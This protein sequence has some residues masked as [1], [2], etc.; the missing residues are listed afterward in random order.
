[1]ANLWMISDLHLGHKGILT[2]DH[3]DGGKLRD[4]DSL[5]QM[6]EYIFDIWQ[7]TVGAGDKVYVLG[8]VAFNRQA[9]LRMKDLKGSKR[10][11][12]GNHDLFKQKDYNEVFTQTYGVRQINRVWLTHVPM[13]PHSMDRAIVNVHGHLHS[14]LV[15]DPRY[16]NVSVEQINYK[17]ISM[18]T[19]MA[20]AKSRGLL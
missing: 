19:V 17:P 10:L 4:F 13:H 7:D 12:R 2:F 20:T 16:I 3:P 18:D 6:E 14:G 15:D 5:D 11:I 9:L 1:M 8:D